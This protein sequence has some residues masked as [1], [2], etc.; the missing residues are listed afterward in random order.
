MV[1]SLDPIGGR[2]TQVWAVFMDTSNYY[3]QGSSWS[4]VTTSDP[5]SQGVWLSTNSP[6]GTP[7]MAYAPGTSPDGTAP[8]TITFNAG[9]SIKLPSWSDG[10]KYKVYVRAENTAG[11]RLDTS[12]A[13]T[14]HVFVFDQTSPTMTA[15]S[16]I[17]ALALDSNNPS[18]LI[19]FS[20]ASGTV[21]DNM[22]DTLNPRQIFLRILDTVTGKYL[23]PST[24]ISFDVTAAGSAWAQIDPLG[25]AWDYGLGATAFVAGNKYKLE[26]YANDKAGNDHVGNCATVEADCQTG[27]SVSPKYVRYFKID[28]TGPVLAI[29]TPTVSVPNNIGLST[30]LASITGTASDSGVGVD[31]V[32]Y[33]LRFNKEDPTNHW[34]HHVTSGSWQTGYV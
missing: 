25:Q 22:T 34:L 15:H 21:V 1:L 27:T 19:A 10:R 2:L 7:D 16:G 8:V 11:Q 3:W 32:E 31:Y 9:T 17:T 28:K 5:P 23:N 13:V 18:L 26:L 24:L 20:L 30:A 6:A 12:L 29:S 4:A 14:T 33:T